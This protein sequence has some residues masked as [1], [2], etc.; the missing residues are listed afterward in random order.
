V[1]AFRQREYAEDL[2]YQLLMQ[3]FPAYILQED[4]YYKVQV[5]AYRQLDNAV[6]MEETLRRQGYSTFI[7]T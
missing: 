4:G 3:N 6:K 7:T 2:L 1:G 5:G